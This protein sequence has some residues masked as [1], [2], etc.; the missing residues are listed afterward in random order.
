ML[1]CM[2]RMLASWCEHTDTFSRR[3]VALT[4]AVEAFLMRAE[5]RADVS[6]LR[7]RSCAILVRITAMRAFLV[8]ML[9]FTDALLI[10]S[11]GIRTG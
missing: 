9:A 5:Y 7:E 2:L 4:D 6:L 10:V 11:V 8:S 1:D 3:R